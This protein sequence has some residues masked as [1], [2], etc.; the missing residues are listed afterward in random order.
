MANAPQVVYYEPDHRTPYWGQDGQVAR[1]L[2]QGV[3]VLGCRWYRLL[4]GGGEDSRE[5]EGWEGGEERELGGRL[6]N[7]WRRSKGL[8]EA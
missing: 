4:Q 1:R 8:G 6:L 3:G 5:E 7:R 2:G